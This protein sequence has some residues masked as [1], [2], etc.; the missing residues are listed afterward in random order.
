MRRS[1][2]VLTVALTVLLAGCAGI[3]VDGTGADDI[4]VETD[5]GA[6]SVELESDDNEEI[7]EET[8]TDD[9]DGT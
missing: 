8:E 2:L 9:N 1:V 5:D 6:D 3:D 7:D 4:D